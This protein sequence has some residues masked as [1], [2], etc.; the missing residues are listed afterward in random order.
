MNCTLL[1][2]DVMLSNH[3]LWNSVANGERTA[4]SLSKTIK[5]NDDDEEDEMIAMKSSANGATFSFIGC[6]DR[7]DSL[8]VSPNSPLRHG[9]VSPID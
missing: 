4:R 1:S 7:V 2:F 3:G 6:I 8:A 5:M 9:G